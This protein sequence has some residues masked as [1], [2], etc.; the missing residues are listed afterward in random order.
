MS[1]EAWPPRKREKVLPERPDPRCQHVTL[2]RDACAG[3][4]TRRTVRGKLMSFQSPSLWRF[5]RQEPGTHVTG[6]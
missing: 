1:Q 4:L 5:V 6:S 3:V 2:A